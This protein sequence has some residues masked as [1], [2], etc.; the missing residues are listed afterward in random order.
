MKGFKIFKLFLFLKIEVIR[1]DHIQ[2][3]IDAFLGDKEELLNQI[4]TGEYT[5]TMDFPGIA[6]FD[7][8]L[9]VC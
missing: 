9:K 8:L 4:E 6:V 5:A 3:W 1:L 7:D 2:L